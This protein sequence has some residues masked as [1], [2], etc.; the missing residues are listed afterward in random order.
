[1]KEIILNRAKCNKCNDIIT[2]Y[3]GHDYITC[4]CGLIA[5]DG[6]TNYLR[7]TGEPSDMTEMSIDSSK[8]FKIIRENYHRGGRGKNGNEQLKWVPMS[9]MSDNW[10]LACIEYNDDR[11]LGKS[12]AN[13]MYKK[14][15]TYRKKN[16]ITITE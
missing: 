4:K 13:K 10:L 9:E 15:L 7:R 11:G 16:K 6:G 12:F 8:P 14:E 3:H 5:V 2:S 1:M